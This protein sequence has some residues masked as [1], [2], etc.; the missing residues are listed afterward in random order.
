MNDNVNVDRQMDDAYYLVEK[1]NDHMTRIYMDHV[2]FTWQWWVALF[3]CIA[4]W[5]LWIIYRKK[6]STWRLL[7]SGMFVM[8]I[9]SWLDSVGSSFDFWHYHYDVLPTIPS[10]EPWDFTLMPVTI[11]FLLQIMPNINPFLKAVVFGILSAFVAEP[12]FT[13]I[14]LYHTENWKF[15][16][17]FP[18]YIVIYLIALYL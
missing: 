8:L 3:L 7:S 15:I 10:Y 11:M 17:S 14:G 4:P 16:Y 6:D 9:S 18:I 13:W 12:F 2:L 1:A 5:V